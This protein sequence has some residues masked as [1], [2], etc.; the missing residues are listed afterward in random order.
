M[1]LARR[2]LILGTGVYHQKDG[3]FMILF[4]ALFA[5]YIKGVLTLF[6]RLSRENGVT[7]LDSKSW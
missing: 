2:V 4:A 5:L 1:T 6:K 7:A 3:E